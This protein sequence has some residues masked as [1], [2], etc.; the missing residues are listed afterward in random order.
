MQTELSICKFPLSVSGDFCG[1]PVVVLYYL[2][3]LDTTVPVK[4][5]VVSLF[6]GSLE[7][8]AHLMYAF[9][10]CQVLVINSCISLAKAAS[11]PRVHRAVGWFVV[12]GLTALSD[13][14]SVYI[15]PSPKEREKEKK[16]V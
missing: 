2:S 10:Y 1:Q 6:L 16:N 15:G 12:L 11:Q 5:K 9:A 13:R 3:L 8:L 14:I 7:T 4:A